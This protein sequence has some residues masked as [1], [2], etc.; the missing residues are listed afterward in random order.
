MAVA[1]NEPA[2]FDT[3]AFDAQRALL[4]I[5]I[6]KT[7]GSAIEDLVYRAMSSSARYFMDTSMDRLVRCTPVNFPRIRIIVHMPEFYA[8]AA[9][10]ECLHYTRNIVSFAVLRHPLERMLSAWSHLRVVHGVNG[11][12]RSFHDYIVHDMQTFPNDLGPY[13]TIFALPQ[14]SFIGPCTI[15]FASPQL[16]EGWLK[17]NHYPMQPAMRRVNAHSNWSPSPSETVVTSE[18]R[19]LIERIF[20]DDYFLWHALQAANGNIQPSCSGSSEPL[21]SNE[22]DISHAF[23]LGHMEC[24]RHP[25]RCASWHLANYTRDLRKMNQLE[26]GEQGS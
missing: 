13:K 11:F 21:D 20:A 16:A 22:N 9:I 10:R 8:R 6:P 18:A 12:N 14:S 24:R 2:P 15:L 7:G 1:G 17:A 26:R 3:W 4:F 25:E 23:G 19:N 5:H